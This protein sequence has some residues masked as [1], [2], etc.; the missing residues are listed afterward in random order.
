[1]DAPTTEHSKTGTM[2][3]FEMPTTD[4]KKSM[5]FYK[6]VLGWNF[7]PMGPTYWLIEIDSK[8][9]GGINLETK[10][11]FK[12][13]CGFRPFFT[14]PSVK[15]GGSMITKAGGKLIGSTVD[16]SNGE[17]GY[18]QHFTD[19]DNNAVSIWSMKP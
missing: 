14:V 1:M 4:E 19:L 9:I 13:A 11:T 15:E 3:W 17:M 10:A 6:S 12:P 8:S 2:S 16:I 5:A 7:K 18:F